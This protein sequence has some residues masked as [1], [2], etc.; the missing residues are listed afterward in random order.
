MSTGLL[1]NARLGSIRLKK[2][3]LCLINKQ[4][5]LMYLI[6]R[7]HNTFFKE[8]QSKGILLI[9]A[10]ADEEENRLFEQYFQEDVNIFYGSLYN[11]PLRHLQVA[12]K[13]SVENIISVDGDDIL[14]SM[15]G[16]RYVY[17]ALNSGCG[18]V[19]TE[20]LPFGMNSFGYKKRILYES[21]SGY[22][23]YKLETGWG[24]IF[25]E[26]LLH[27]ITF[28]KN[29]NTENL[30]FTLDYP[31]DLRFFEEII[32]RVGSRIYTISDNEIINLVIKDK[33]FMINANV[34][35]MY[36]DNFYKNIKKEG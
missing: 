35:K 7:I 27:S 8:I 17:N 23:S 10:T 26:K 2:K 5:I 19:K 21:L 1:I 20:N 9:L 30:R 28:K 33:L 18:Y 4:P 31:E 22:K 16:I 3:H 15:E 24:R 32:K 14:C 34:E 11:I 13:Y 6:K 29:L 25:P 36:W 12:E